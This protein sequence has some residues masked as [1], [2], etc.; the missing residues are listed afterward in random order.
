[1]DWNNELECFDT[2]L[3]ELALFYVPEPLATSTT[4]TTDD[5]ETAAERH[6]ELAV[7]VESVLFPAFR[8][9]LIPTNELLGSVT[10][11]ANLKGLYRI[12]ERS[13]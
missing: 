13:C 7:A 9:R 4:S 2:F 3:R 11:I 6:K 8:K 10:E 5:P 12:F 1:V